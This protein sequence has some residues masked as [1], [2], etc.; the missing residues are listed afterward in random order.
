MYKVQ[1]PQAFIFGRN[2]WQRSVDEAVKITE[3]IRGL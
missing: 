1:A 2:I 3:K